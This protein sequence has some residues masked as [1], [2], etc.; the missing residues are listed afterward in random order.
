MELRKITEIKLNPNNPR[1]IKD[2]KFKKLVQSIKDFPEM[3]DIRPIVVNKDMI[4]LGGNMRFRACKEAGIKEIP[5]IVTDLSEDKQR[6]FLI[7]DNTS[8]GEWDWDM[9]ANEWDTDE[10]EAWGL[11]LPVFDIKDEGTAE[12]DNYEVPDTIETD[13]VLGDLFEIGE[14]RLL[15]GD[16]TDS[17]AV[18]KL[19]NGKKADMVFTDPPYG[20]KLDADYSGMKSD[21]FKGGIG[22]KKYDNIKGDHE[23]FTDELINTIFSHFADIKE[24]FIWGADYFA[25]LLPNKNDGSWVVWDKRANGNDDIEEDKSSDK[26]YGSTFELCW[27]KNKH[28]RDIA[29]IKW[30]GIFGMPSQDTKGRVHPTQKPIELANWFFKRWGKEKDLVVDL[31]L[32]GGTTMVASHQLNRKCYGM[33]LDPK[34]C[35]VIVDRMIKLDST[36]VIKKNGQP[37][38]L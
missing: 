30:A 22:G 35:Q 31:Y 19:M 4:I 23:D 1:L 7:K 32:G 29:R 25:E 18:A 26:M 24:M 11:D 5:V 9:L 6:E 21:I 38:G 36:L 14:H 2:D 10:L 28:K 12:E 20:M 13:I 8:G 3:L 15:C 34:Y 27:S 37:Y 33:E 16:S 17:D